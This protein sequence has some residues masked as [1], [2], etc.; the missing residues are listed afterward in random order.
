MLPVFENEMRWTA[1]DYSSV[2]KKDNSM[3]DSTIVRMPTPVSILA[4]R[5]RTAY[6]QAE[7]SHA[8]WINAV[9]DMAAILYEARERF[10]NNLKFSVWL[11]ENDLGFHNDDDRAALINMHRN[12]AQT[13]IVLQETLRTSLQNIWRKEIEPRLRYVNEH[14]DRS[15]PIPETP[16]VV[17]ETLKNDDPPAPKP[18]PKTAPPITSRSSFYDAPRAQEIAAKLLDKKARAT[19]SHVWD[20]RNG[21]HIW[22]LITI[23]LDAGL[24]VESTHAIKKPTMRLLFP[25]APFSYARRFDLTN[26]HQR[27]QIKEETLPAM[28]AC[29]DQL[30]AAPNNIAAI[31]SAYQAA[32]T[33][34]Q[35]AVVK[36]ERHA[37]AVKALP[38]AEQELVMFGHPVWPRPNGNQGEYTYDQARAAI[39]TFRDYEAW[40]VMAREDV[41]SLAKRIR[42]SQRY[43][44]E[45]V[46]RTG[47][48][49]PVARV[50][51]LIMWFSHLMEK[52]P[53][54]ECKWPMYPHI[55]GQW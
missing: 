48:E 37:V 41:E 43:I 54:A 9:L 27:K 11:A 49:Q 45:F 23:A 33:A 15:T 5:Y 12:R 18:A 50:Y 10:S 25:P 44:G 1:Q 20:D 55:E 3:T 30:L 29:R 42:N 36:A 24:L 32:Q 16:S 13:E 31:L 46:R 34:K 35:T 39:W 22:E 53:T 14:S 8:D 17:A 28:I 47:R 38:L 26:P 51:S 52:N 4:D 2:E 19:L 40:N 21:K 7:H 6:A